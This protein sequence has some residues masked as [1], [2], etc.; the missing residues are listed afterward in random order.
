M[1][2][3]KGALRRVAAL[4]TGV[5]LFGA[6]LTG[7]LAQLDLKNYPAPF[8]V[9][10]TYDTANAIVVGAKAAASD[11][12]AA[13]DIA[14]NLQF[15]SKTCVAKGSGSQVSVNGDAVQV[16]DGSDLLELDEPIGE[17]RETLTDVELN[18]LRS[19]TITTNEGSTT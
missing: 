18:G 1:Q 6:T 8:V 4:G 2:R 9:D 11:T 7:A 19:G 3:L 10:G 5:A 16:S 12:L 14:S 17:V 15:E 13:V